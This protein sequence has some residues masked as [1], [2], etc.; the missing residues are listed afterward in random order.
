MFSQH[1]SAL[2]RCSRLLTYTGGPP[3]RITPVAAATSPTT[4]S[5]LRASV[6]RFPAEIAAADAEIAAAQA[7][8]AE[9]RTAQEKAEGAGASWGRPVTDSSRRRGGTTL[10]KR[11][12]LGRRRV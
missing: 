8:A 5:V 9:L 10:G 12:R 2:V 11:R 1:T 4:V 3:K 7:K 6:A